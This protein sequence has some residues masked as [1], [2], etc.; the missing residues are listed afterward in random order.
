M[1]RV[2]QI[3]T[4]DLFKS[5]MR[6]LKI[7]ERDRIFC[8]H[9]IEHLLSVA[10]IMR[11]KALEEN[12]KTDADIIYAAALLHDIG[13]V[14]AYKNGSDHAKESAKIAEQILSD[15]NF[16]QADKEKILFA[17]L[18]HNDN[19]AADEL[20]DLLRAA[21]K[22]SR[23]CFDCSAYEECNW[24]EERKNKGVKI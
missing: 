23:N 16:E 18:H 4:N 14:I 5:Y 20:C 1:N 11:I 12:M 9:D 10:R 21:D 19:K 15:C 22:L 24:L 6:E 13:R 3:L 17:I 2:N 7:L 8:K